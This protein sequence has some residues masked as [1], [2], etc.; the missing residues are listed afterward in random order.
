[1]ECHNVAW[2]DHVMCVILPYMGITAPKKHGTIHANM[3][4][5][6][7][8]IKDTH[9][10]TFPWLI[11]SFD[12]FFYINTHTHTHI[13]THTHTHLIYMLYERKYKTEI[14]ITQDN[15][16]QAENHEES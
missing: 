13:Y 4:Q 9:V 2:L 3:Y 15:I 5:A 6:K 16:H 8:H 10:T 11:V 12:P 7:H 14:I 1:M